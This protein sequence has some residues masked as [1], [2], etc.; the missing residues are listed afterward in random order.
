MTK[1]FSTLLIACL[2]IGAMFMVS[3]DLFPEDTNPEHIHEWED[4]VVEPTCVE[5]GY[6][7]HVC[8]TCG[9][10]RRD[11]FVEPTA[12]KHEYKEEKIA[13]TCTEY[14]CTRLTCTVCGDVVEKDV[15]EAC[16][17]WSK[18][19]VVVEPS[20]ADKGL[21]RRDCAYCDEFEYRE[22]NS[23]HPFDGGVVT[24]PDCETAGYTTY[25]CTLCGYQKKDNTT[26]AK[27]H[28][29]G[30]WYV[31][32]DSTCTTLGEARRDCEVEGCDGYESKVILTHHYDIA[33]SKAP[34]CDQYGYEGSQCVDCGSI[35]IEVTYEKLEHGFNE[36][37]DVIGGPNQEQR[38]CESCGHTEYRNKD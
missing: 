18:W 38:E 25:T 30:E 5:A 36:W 10:E 15:V 35:R 1:L 13:P 4:T 11:T 12:Q 19:V 28:T 31:Y 9:Y 26:K 20:C 33:V 23:A 6:T 22:T 16:H 24:E 3:C 34:T 17:S 37:H 14:G 21:E 29:F 7:H 8:K 2:L 27:G 32:V